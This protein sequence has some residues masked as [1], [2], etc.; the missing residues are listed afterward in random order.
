MGAITGR[1]T[2]GDSYLPDWLEEGIDSSLRDTEADMPRTPV[3][4]NVTQISSAR[5]IGSSARATPVV[6][7]PTG[8]SPSGSVVRQEGTKAAYM[9]LDRFYE[10]AEETEESED[11]AS[12]DEEES[13]GDSESGS[14]S[15]EE[16][17]STE[18][19]ESGDD[20]GEEDGEDNASDNH[21]VLGTTG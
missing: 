15:G 3:S 10:D 12:E 5:S 8:I 11:S 16:V 4:A 18:E 6:L 14:G 9:D 2:G 1:W 21:H 17:E 7:T 19:G 20:D 13:E